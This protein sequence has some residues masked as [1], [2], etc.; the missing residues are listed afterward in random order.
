M[1]DTSKPANIPVVAILALLVFASLYFLRGFD[2]NRLTSW[3]WV[4]RSVS[5]AKAYVAVAVGILIAWAALR[6]PEP[7]TAT[8]GLI[9]FAIGV[10]FWREP[11]VIV[12]VSRYFTQAKYLSTY[13]PGYFV[14]EWG[15]GIDA[16]TDLPAIPFIYGVGF[17]VFGESRL[18][19]QAITT[20]MFAATVVMTSR[21]G[22]ALWNRE[23]GLSAG[24][25]MM[26]VPYLYT[27]VPLM[28]VDVPSMFFLLLALYSFISAVKTGGA[29]RTVFAALAIFIAFF[30][31]YSLWPMLS[32]LAVAWAVFMR[33]D[34]D[35]GRTFRRGGAVFALCLLLV[36]VVVFFKFGFI[37]KQ[38]KLLLEY[39][40]P[41]L[42]RWTESFTSTFL[43]QIHPFLT[44]GAIYSIWRAVRKR[45][46]RC[47]IIF[48]LPAL[49]FLMEIKRIRYIVP[50]VPMFAL[51]A[52]Y[53]FNKLKDAELRRFAISSAVVASVAIAAFAYLP[54]L[55][56]LSMVNIV[57]A[58]SY[59][60]GLGADRVRVFT[61]EMKS[62]VNP[63]VSVPIL[64]L[65]T[66]KE[67]IYS[68]EDNEPPES[69]TIET[70]PLR[71]TW[72]YRNP[73]Y[74]EKNVSA[75]P[76]I[77]VIIS[78]ERPE[79]PKGYQ[80]NKIFDKSDEIFRF[81]TLVTIYQKEE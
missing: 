11:E 62:Q 17:K 49:V 59:I 53:G 30:S 32:V 81:R 73:P 52:G 3:D 54:F 13:G 68:A 15:S 65:Y 33:E 48:W 45:D 57:D 70:S 44:A 71:F 7:G 28:L 6:L 21:L 23:V 16:W 19:V 72:R 26:A 5:V 47:A 74:Y 40:R 63:A 42:K 51:M 69:V 12:D 27:Q 80:I 76:D 22:S 34:E 29:V 58:G 50:V 41:G 66:N 1:S 60:N 24:A 18:V 35:R 39:Q 43:F 55:R 4:F 38:V 9:S 67:I 61:M 37:E 8:L 64:D 2:D 75:G 56:S 36:G 25:L 14:R 31:K 78:D 79:T 10:L 46:L 77:V 20:S